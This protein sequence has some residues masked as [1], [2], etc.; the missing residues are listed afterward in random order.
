MVAW[1][2]T[3]GM[4]LSRTTSLKNPEVMDRQI[5]TEPTPQQNLDNLSFVI[6]YFV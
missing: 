6:N 4:N 5:D 2:P 3:T 1:E